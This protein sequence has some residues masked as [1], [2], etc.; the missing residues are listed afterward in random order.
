M[1]S[2]VFR[3]FC[4]ATLLSIGLTTD[5]LAGSLGL[6]AETPVVESSAAV[7]DYF[8]FGGDGDLSTFGAVVD[9]VD[10]VSP[11]GLTEIGFGVGFDLLDP[12]V[13]AT[14]GFDVVDED[15]LLLGGDLTSV[16]FFEDVIEFVFS[17]LSGSAAGDFG[18]S[19]LAVVAFAD[20]LGPDPFSS[21]IDGQSYLASVSISRIAEDATVPAPSAL[22]LVLSALGFVRWS[23]RRRL[24]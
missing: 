3:A 4:A 1:K 10:G 17:N 5:T 16:G 7:L 15:G 2:S 19:V 11:N 20:A 21:L 6:D 8:E 23:G 18:T 14:G 9:F 22:L 12:T 13:G 24:G